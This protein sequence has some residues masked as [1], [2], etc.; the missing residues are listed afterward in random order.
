MKQL[1]A[2]ENNSKWE[3]KVNTILKDIV[4]LHGHRWEQQLPSQQVK[5]SKQ[6]SDG[7]MIAHLHRKQEMQ[8]S[9]PSPGKNVLLKMLISLY[10]QKTSCLNLNL[11][12]L[13]YV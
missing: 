4:C 6:S 10:L 12:S 8:G 3:D 9:S 1:Q 13:L 11:G 2:L 5:G 7:E